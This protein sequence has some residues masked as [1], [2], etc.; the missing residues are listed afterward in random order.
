[1][2]YVFETS[3]AEVYLEYSSAMLYVSECY[4]VICLWNVNL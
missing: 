1:M 2:L 4:N 3:I